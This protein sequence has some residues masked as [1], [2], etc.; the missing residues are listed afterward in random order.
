MNIYV[1]DR[2]LNRLGIIDTYT[3]LIWIRKTSTAGR[4]ELHCPVNTHTIDLLQKDRVICKSNDLTECAYIENRTIT[5]DS[6]G[7][8][9]LKVTGKFVSGYLGKRIIWGMFNLNMTCEKAMRKLVDTQ[10]INTSANRIIPFLTLDTEQGYTCKVDYQVSYKN[11][12]EELESLSNVSD[13]N[14]KV[15]TDLINKNHIFKIYSGVDRTVNQNINSICIFSK[16]FENILDS[17]FT[18]NTD[19][20][21]NTAL[22]AG[23]GE[24]TDRVLKT[25][26]N[27]TGLDR[28]EIFIDAKDIQSKD[29]NENIIPAGEYDKLLIQRGHEKLAEYKEVETFESKINVTNSNLIYKQDFDLGDYV[30][31]QNREWNVTTNVKITE[32]EEVYESDGLQVNV[33]FGESIPT[34]ISKIKAKMR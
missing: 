10:C 8:E 5:Q 12:L 27:S 29:E 11:L 15:Y 23:E 7:K 2:E 25:I 3:S 22:I 13:L 34:L 6:N 24:G 4:F 26:E 31:C 30:T 21:R 16:N 14:F 18:H 9:T 33:T 32:I 1:F 20:Y 17:E 28:N 19:N